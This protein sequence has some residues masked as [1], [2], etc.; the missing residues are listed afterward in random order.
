MTIDALRRLI[1]LLS[2]TASYAAAL[3]RPAIAA[4]LATAAEAAQLLLDDERAA[5]RRARR[6]HRTRR[7]AVAA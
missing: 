6:T 5:A 2:D 3:D 7:T 4:D 1:E